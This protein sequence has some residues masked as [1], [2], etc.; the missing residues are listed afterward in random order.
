M[1]RFLALLLIAAIIIA[2]ILFFTNP[3][4]LD[5]VW[6]WLIGFAG[7]IIGLFRNLWE[8]VKGAFDKDEEV[9]QKVAPEPLAKEN[10]ALAQTQVQLKEAEL[11]L[12]KVQSQIAINKAELEEVV[13]FDGTT[14]S[15]IRFRYDQNT[16]LGLL[17][18]RDQFIAYTL[19]DTYRET[20]IKGKT[21]IPSGVYEIKFR[22]VMSGLTKKYRERKALQ[23]FFTW[24]LELQNVPN[25][26]FVYI[27]IG[28][29]HGDTDGCILIADGIYD[30]SIK[31][32]IMNSVKAYTRFYKRIQALLEGGE[33]VRIKVYDENWITQLQRKST[34]SEEVA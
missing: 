19:E 21:R 26:E 3:Q 12:K 8:S 15:L 20:K 2:I 9:V 34:I 18:I 30:D 32:S 5:G 14:L 10:V 13:P 1:K 4:L 24:H 6:L 33:K 17:Y 25:Y 16:T 23:P 11:E 28:N 27:H 22:E 31:K 7:S 29:T